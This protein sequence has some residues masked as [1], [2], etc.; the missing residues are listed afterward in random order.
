MGDF[1]QHAG[2]MVG[3]DDDDGG[4]WSPPPAADNENDADAR[5]VAGLAFDARSMQHELDVESQACRERGE[6]TANDEASEINGAS[7]P[8]RLRESDLVS[9]CQAHGGCP[10]GCGWGVERGRQR[11]RSSSDQRAAQ[12]CVRHDVVQYLAIAK[13][14]YRMER[15]RRSTG[16]C[17]LELLWVLL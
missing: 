12:R 6:A 9:V 14:V 11:P 17:Y 1:G 7:Q 10:C 16:R 4:G 3:P 13:I 15:F 8:P 2:G 5:A